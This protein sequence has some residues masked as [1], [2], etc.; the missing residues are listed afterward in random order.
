MIVI[1]L[2]G[3]PGSGKSTTTAGLFFLLKINKYKVEQV[4][5][6]AKEL[7]WEGRENVFGDQVSIF[8]EQNRRLLR[9]QAH[10]LDYAISDSPLPLPVLY[11]PDGYLRHFDALVMEQF[12]RYENINYLLHR[13]SDF[14]TIGRRHN[15]EE[16]AAM[17][18]KMRVF[19]DERKVPYTCLEANP[20]TPEAILSDLQ[21][22]APKPVSSIPFLH[23]P[24]AHAD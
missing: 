23:A 14:E 12:D 19:L 5:E 15:E 24:N 16:A 4:N 2:W 7:V 9:L 13:T 17:A 18:Q 11:K 22:R 3:E 8:A 10:G 6:F 20:L 21:Q 1:N